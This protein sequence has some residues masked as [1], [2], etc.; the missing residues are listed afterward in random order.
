MQ[1]TWKGGC[2]IASVI[3]LALASI[4]ALVI[5]LSYPASPAPA[6]APA[7]WFTRFGG[8]CFVAGA[9]LWDISDHINI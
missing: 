1:L 9:L 4:S 8:F 7:S 6:P 5:G 3:L 2:F